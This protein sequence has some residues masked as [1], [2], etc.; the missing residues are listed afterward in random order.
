VASKL[1]LGARHAYRRTD[2]RLRLDVQ[3]ARLW[4]DQQNPDQVMQVAVLVIY[5]LVAVAEAVT[6][7]RK[8]R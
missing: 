2:R 1:L 5:G 8:G 7:K 3:R 4:L 6:Y